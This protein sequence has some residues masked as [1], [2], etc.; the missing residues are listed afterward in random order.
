MTD[1]GSL[2]SLARQWLMSLDRTKL[3]TS[4]PTITLELMLNGI[5]DLAE[6]PHQVEMNRRAQAAHM[7]RVLAATKVSDGEGA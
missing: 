7:A 6:P 1:P 2:A 3:E 5:V 4:I